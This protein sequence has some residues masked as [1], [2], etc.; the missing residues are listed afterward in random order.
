MATDNAK[1]R[2]ASGDAMA[3]ARRASGEAMAASRRAGGEAMVQRRTGAAEVA[4]INA[5]VSQPRQ[6]ATLRTVEP[7]GALPAQ[8]GRGT[9]EA[10]AASTGGGI[11]SPLT[12]QSVEY[13]SA[14]IPSTDGLF[15]LPARKTWTFNDA[16]GA[17]VV[18]DFPEPGATP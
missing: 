14:G 1:A 4:D 18:F 15:V 7:R 16:N 10:P 6:R 2:R 5:V 12:E 11:A 17:E 8:R 3:K 9:Y 13:W